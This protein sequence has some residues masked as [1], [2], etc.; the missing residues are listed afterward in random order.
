MHSLHALNAASGLDG[1]I[2]QDASDHRVLGTKLDLFHQQEEGPGMVFWHPR[3]MALYRVIEDYIRRRMREAGFAEIRTPQLLSMSLWEQSGHADKFAN[4]MFRLSGTHMGRRSSAFAL[5]PMSCPGH[6][7]VFNKRLRSVHELP[8]RY[9]EFGV[10]HRDEPSG[11]LQ[12]L[13]RA[14]A[15]T[16]DDAHIFCTEEQVE[17]EV[18]RFCELLRSIYRDF[19]FGSLLVFFSTRP[20]KRAGDNATWDRAEAALVMAA[21]KAG[22]D[23]AIKQ[24]DG[25][26][27]GPKLEFHLRDNHGR[28][29]QCGT[30]QLDFVLPERLGAEYVTSDN[31]RAHPVMIHHAVLGSLERFIGMLLEHHQGALPLWLAPEQILVANVAAAHEAYARKAAAALGREGYRVVVDARGERLTRKIAEAHEQGVPL[32][33]V[34]GE[35]EAERGSLS[36]RWRDGRQEELSLQ[37]AARRF[38]AE[39]FR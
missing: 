10:C 31:G 14:R 3:G 2:G 27:Y 36:F 8:L 5:K 15:F 39:A 37:E 23:F 1:S 33:A 20:A 13:M 11:A 38:R 18:Q 30:V 34:A 7:Q 17:G 28:A 16:Q 25:A 4:E 19:G 32:V 35:R 12:G 29:W 24:G 6:I 9:C 26:F 22:L 21:R